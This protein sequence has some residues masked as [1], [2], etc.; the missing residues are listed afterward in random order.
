MGSRFGLLTALAFSIAPLGRAHDLP[1]T[2]LIRDLAEERQ[3]WPRKRY[4]AGAALAGAAL[5]AL[6]ILTS[7]QRSIAA[8]VAGATVAAFLAL[9]LVALRHRLLARRAP[10]SRFVEWRMALAAIERPGALTASV[11]L[12]LGL[13]LA[14][15]VAL[16]LIDANMRAE[17]L[18]VRAR[19]DAELLFPRCAAAPTPARFV[20]S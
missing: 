9:R 19:R 14:A 3:G 4:L 11:V 2:T 1:V 15:L 13:G 6:A 17:L 5:V 18:R 8:Y 7:P 16:T 20:T 10:K 12:S